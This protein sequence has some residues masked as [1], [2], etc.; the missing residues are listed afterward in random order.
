MV[1]K[2]IDTRT[3]ERYLNLRRTAV[4]RGPGVGRNYFPLTG[5]LKGH[6]VYLLPFFILIV[7]YQSA[8]A[9]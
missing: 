1:G 6:Q 4:F 8:S 2:L 7:G 9:Q 5:Y 3:M